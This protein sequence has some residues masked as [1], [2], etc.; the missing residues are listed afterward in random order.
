MSVKEQALRNAIEKLHIELAGYMEPAR[1]QKG[2]KLL[3]ELQKMLNDLS[4]RGSRQ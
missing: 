2:E 3:A 1:R 4:N